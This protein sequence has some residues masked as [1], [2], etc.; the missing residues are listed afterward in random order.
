[1]LQCQPSPGEPYQCLLIR[2]L[3]FIVKGGTFNFQLFSLQWL[4]LYATLCSFPKLPV[5]EAIQHTFP[6]KKYQF[7]NLF[8]CSFECFPLSCLVIHWVNVCP[9]QRIHITTY[10]SVCPGPITSSLGWFYAG[11]LTWK[12]SAFVHWHFHFEVLSNWV[13]GA[14]HVAQKRVNMPGFKILISCQESR[15]RR[16]PHRFPLFQ[17]KKVKLCFC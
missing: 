17:H 8:Y 3:A 7:L 15:C 10:I 2:V 14:H 16:I 13:T 4:L 1:M 6:S 11:L 9:C 12:H 5:S